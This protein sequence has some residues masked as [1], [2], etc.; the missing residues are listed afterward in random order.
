MT[1]HWT[2]LAG[3]I[4][5]ALML[6]ACSTTPQRN[7]MLD[8]ARDAF[9]RAAA[10]NQ[11]AQYAP[12]ELG[13]ARDALARAE[14]AWKDRQEDTDVNHLAYLAQ[15][16]AQVAV[17]VGTQRAADARVE[18]AGAERERLRT[19]IRTREAQTAQASARSAQAQAQFAQT[20]AQNAQA[21]A[22]AE[23][24]RAN[25]LQQELATLQAKPTD[26][27]L[28]VMLQDVLFDTGQAVLKEGAQ[29]RLAQLATVLKNHPERRILVEGFTDSVGSDAANMELS[30]A[31]ADAVRKALLSR[32]VPADRIETR[33]YGE[34][35]PV[36]SNA[37]PA[38]RQQN[39]RVEVV[40]SDEQGKFAT[41]R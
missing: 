19:E 5:T 6:G 13:R 3:G 14:S 15:K 8:E 25:R 27:G 37:N 21:R 20:Q 39:R 12:A 7:A 11:V 2:T 28:V 18:T 32:G 38:G 36:A 41:M 23:A 9:D 10:N 17:N 30:Q 35:R 31:R 26:H 24:E 40:F 16:R 34:S 29:A 1:R 4:A 22:A 33:G